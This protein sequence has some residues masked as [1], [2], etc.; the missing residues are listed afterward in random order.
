[1]LYPKPC[2][3]ELCYKEVEVYMLLSCVMKKPAFCIFDRVAMVMEKSL[4][5]E[6]FSR[7]G[8]SQGISILVREI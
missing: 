4:E 8:K 2:Y 6:K 1:M 7:S 3:N 5:N